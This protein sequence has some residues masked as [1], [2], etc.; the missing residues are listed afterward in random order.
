ML[1][2]TTHILPIDETSNSEVTDTSVVTKTKPEE[3]KVINPEDTKESE[4]EEVSSPEAATMEA[5]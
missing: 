2:T 5:P 3:A 1:F 4:A